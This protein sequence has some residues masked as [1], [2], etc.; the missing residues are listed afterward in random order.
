MPDQAPPQQPPAAQ[1]PPAPAAPASGEPLTLAA[2]DDKIDALATALQG[3]IA[4]G[5]GKAAGHTERRLDRPSVVE[6]QVRAELEKLTAERERRERE[7]GQAATIKSQGEQLEQLRKD[8][9]EAPPAEPVR[10][11]TRWIW[12][13]PPVK[14][15]R[16]AAGSK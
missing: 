9:T 2:L 4:S 10:R 11:L 3:F 5:H 16:Q 14:G 13:E 15:A 8:L 12:G 7:E 6:E 1:Q